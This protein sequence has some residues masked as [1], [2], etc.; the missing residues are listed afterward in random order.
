MLMM[1][2][3]FH[4]VWLLAALLG[5]AGIDAK[6]VG[7]TTFTIG[8]AY[9]EGKDDYG[10]PDPALGL[11]NNDWSAA[12]SGEGF[13]FSVRHDR[14]P[15]FVQASF[16]S[17]TIRHRSNSLFIVCFN[18][19]G[20]PQPPFPSCERWPTRYEFDDDYR[21]GELTVGGRLPLTEAW[22]TWG[23]AGLSYER[24]SSSG[25]TLQSFPPTGVVASLDPVRHSES[26]W[27]AGAGVSRRTQRLN[28]DFG[29][30]YQPE[31]YFPST[32]VFV[33]TGVLIPFES[34]G[35]SSLLEG[36]ARA[37]WYFTPRWFGRLEYRPSRQRQYLHAGLGI[38][39]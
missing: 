13:A 34:P 35:S 30:H 4:S 29:V 28:L 1:R 16:E 21:S 23:Q 19:A 36:I 7:K 17:L 20:A 37:D 9:F 18:Q 3:R 11:A 14:G 5:L 38:A 33:S 31:G 10:E 2:P 15:W 39:F 32:G 8:P 25:G 27:T 6:A 26:T 12:D 24:W 22:S